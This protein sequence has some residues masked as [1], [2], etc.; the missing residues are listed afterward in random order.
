MPGTYSAKGIMSLTKI[1]GR[2][3]DDAVEINTTIDGTSAIVAI[4]GNLTVA[5]TPQLEAAFSDLPEE[6]ADLTLDLAE[7]DYVA[8]A[9]LRVLVSQAK[10]MQRKSGT[11]RITNPNEEV[12]EVFDVTGLVDILDIVQ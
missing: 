9:G 8:S 4:V 12:M 7:L 11:M 10:T 6:V 5:T 2:R 1:E 3:K